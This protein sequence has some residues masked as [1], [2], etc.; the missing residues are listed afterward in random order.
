MTTVNDKKTPIEAH[1]DKMLK[2][3]E[4]EGVTITQLPY[5]DRVRIHAKIT[6]PRKK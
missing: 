1:L 6:P 4:K 5:K 2:Q 3:A